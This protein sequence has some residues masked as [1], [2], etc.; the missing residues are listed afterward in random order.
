MMV[1]RVISLAVALHQSQIIQPKLTIDDRST[2]SKMVSLVCTITK[3]IVVMLMFF[4]HSYLGIFVPSTLSI[5]FGLL[6]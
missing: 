6:T 1:D 4:C 2:M 5:T 3:F